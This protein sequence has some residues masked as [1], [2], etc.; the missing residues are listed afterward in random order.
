MAGREAQSVPWFAE[1]RPQEVLAGGARLDGRSFEEFRNVCECMSRAP[2]R[3]GCPQTPTHSPLPSL[4]LLSS[5]LPSAQTPAPPPAPL[6][7]SSR[8]E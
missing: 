4:P 7:Q 2:R 6:L 3:G 1:E 8:R 5:T